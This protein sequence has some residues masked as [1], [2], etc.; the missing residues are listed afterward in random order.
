[1]AT[2]TV[3]SLSTSNYNAL[4][5]QMLLN[6]EGEKSLVY[7]D[8]DGNA[9]IGIGFEVSQDAAAILQG[10]GYSPTTLGITLFNSLVQALDNATGGIHFSTD[11]AAQEKV[12]EAVN[13]VLGTDYTIGTSTTL[14]NNFGY[15]NN[16]GNSGLSAA[17]QAEV[18]FNNIIGTYEQTVDAWLL[19]APAAL[20]TVP[21]QQIPDSNERV[22][23]VS[24][25]Y[26][27]LIGFATDSNGNYLFNSDGTSVVSQR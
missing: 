10:M 22:A 27:N 5:Y 11:S 18:T 2:I 8:S 13:G 15:G 4:L 19:G 25:A 21:P 26:N 7:A 12:N 23:L 9:T 16:T 6:F 17:G 20:G 14:A 3:N 24:L 1:M